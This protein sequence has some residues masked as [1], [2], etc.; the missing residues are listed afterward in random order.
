MDLGYEE[1]ILRRL[2]G[3]LGV[4]ERSIGTLEAVLGDVMRRLEHEAIS[5]DLSPDEAKKEV[6]R[7]ALVLTRES[8]DTEQLE[9]EAARFIG[10]DGYRYGG[11]GRD[12]DQSTVCDR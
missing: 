1:R 2:Y 5:R 4:F 9:S 8:Q 11:G 3:R 7:I 10:A 12:P 6:D